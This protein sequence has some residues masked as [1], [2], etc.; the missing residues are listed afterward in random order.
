MVNTATLLTVA[1]RR[2][3]AQAAFVEALPRFAKAYGPDHPDTASGLYAYGILLY[4]QRAYADAEKAQR[5]ALAI[6]MNKL[7]DDHPDT[8][9]TRA[10]LGKALIEQR[11]YAEAETLLTRAVEVL[12]KAYGVDADEAR[13]ASAA[14]DKV[15]GY[16]KNPAPA[17]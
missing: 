12:N 2:E 17:R 14:L 10:A 6:R 15:R 13:E 5:Q 16:L 1:G 3:E 9:E 7:P 11:Q 8:A 4:K